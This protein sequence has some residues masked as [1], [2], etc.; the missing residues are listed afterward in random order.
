MTYP[1]RRSRTPLLLGLLAA[2]ACSSILAPVG[3]GGER[4][5]GV[6]A[7]YH[8]PVRIAVP[9]TVAVGAALRVVVT[10]YGGGCVTKGDTEVT[11]AARLAEVR[12]FDRYATGGACTEELRLHAH[13]AA[14]RFTHPGQ[15]VVRVQGR[16]EPGDEVFTAERSVF[17]R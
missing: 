13:E 17:V 4:R 16:R 12:P 2:G 11:V 15:A 9:E 5:L 7:F 6:V 14:V 10:T 8:E 1:T 3:R